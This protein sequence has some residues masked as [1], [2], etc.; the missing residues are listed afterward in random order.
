MIGAAAASP[1]LG[2]RVAHGW[3]A[4]QRKAPWR[5]MTFLDDSYERSVMRQVGAAYQ[6]R[7]L[8]LQKRLAT[9]V[10]YRWGPESIFSIHPRGRAMRRQ[11]SAGTTPVQSSDQT[12]DS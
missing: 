7:H 4:V 3:L 6:F 9:D 11:S 10:S 1:W 5:L 2:Y 12:V 8:Q